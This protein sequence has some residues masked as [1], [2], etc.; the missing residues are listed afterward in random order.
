MQQET[1]ILESRSRRWAEEA[2]FFNAEAENIGEKT[3]VIDPLVLARYGQTMPRRRFNKEFRFKIMGPLAG[4]HILDVGCGSGMNAVQ[5]AKLGATVTGIDLS[6]KEIE[7]AHRRAQVNGVSDFVTLMCSPI[8]I[9]DIADNTFDIIWVDAVL[10][11]LLDEL[12]LTLQRLVGWVRPDGLLVFAEPINLFEPLRRLRKLAPARTDVTPGERPLVQTEVD[13][14]LHYLDDP[15][16]RYFMLFGRLDQFVLTRHS[17]E[18][19]SLPRK[20]LS[21][22]IALLDYALLSLP[23]IRRLAGACVIYGRPSKAVLSG[24]REKL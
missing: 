6:R 12:D 21:N 3:L 11:H 22:V 7:L 19:S 5:L 23:G 14:V 20:M 15:K 8:E 16:I 1:D 24:K 18:R 9:A 2:A 10:H 13:S 17:Y 4:K